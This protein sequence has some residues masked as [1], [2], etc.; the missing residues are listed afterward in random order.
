MIK[1]KLFVVFIIV[2]IASFVKGNS[3]ILR[4]FLLQYVGV[5]DYLIKMEVDFH[6]RNVEGGFVDTTLSIDVIVRNGSDFYL[7][8]HAPEI[9]AGI[10][11]AYMAQKRILITRYGDVEE[12]FPGAEQYFLGIKNVLDLLAVFT[13]EE[14]FETEPV[15]Q[16]GNVYR[17]RLP[18]KT[19]RV[20]SLLG[21]DYS[22]VELVMVREDSQYVLQEFNVY[23]SLENEYMKVKV[24]EFASGEKVV[25]EFPQIPGSAVSA[26]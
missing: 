2:L 9:V 21:I 11:L 6:V 8:F 5:R 24:K 19:R 23:N 22:V 17:I 14:A 4:D 13:K 12:V 18:P 25:R 16:E 26:F 15:V 20:L 7:K 3:L 10:E 1:R